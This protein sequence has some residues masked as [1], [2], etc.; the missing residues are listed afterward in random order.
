MT[1]RTARR[2]AWTLFGVS[3]AASAGGFVLLTLVPSRVLARIGD[4]LWLS[5]SFVAV[6]LVFGLVGAI[7]SARLPH[8]PVGW[9]FLGL[10]MI[11]GVN[12]VAYGWAHYSLSVS[13][14]PGEVWVAWSASWSSIVS[15]ALIGLVFVY[16]PDGR[17]LSRRWGWAAVACVALV[18]PAIAQAALVP[19]E[20]A[21][22]P[23]L[24]NPAGIATLGWLAELPAELCFVGILLIGAGSVVVG[25]GAP[26]ASSGRS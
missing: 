23:E 22:F 19:A 24:R 7:L 26:T 6:L 17:P 21:E 25:S 15:P 20:M 13:A 3:S 16:F 2:L 9:L 11:Q 5:G 8:N 10:A 12:E 1:E 14:L 4:S 18:V